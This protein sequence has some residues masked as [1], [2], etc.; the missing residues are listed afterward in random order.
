MKFKDL[1]GNTVFMGEGELVMAN[2]KNGGVDT[3]EGKMIRSRGRNK[4]NYKSPSK[5]GAWGACLS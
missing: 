5:E 1:Q 4:T 3:A 2:S